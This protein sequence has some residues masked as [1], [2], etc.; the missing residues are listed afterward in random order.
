VA[1]DAIRKTSMVETYLC[2]GDRVVALRALQVIVLRGGILSMTA[3]AVGHPVMVKIHI[4][5]RGRG[6]T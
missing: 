2:P 6:V 4:P 1:A 3:D 5:P